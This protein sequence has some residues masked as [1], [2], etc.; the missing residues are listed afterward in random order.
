VVTAAGI[1]LV[2]GD[3]DRMA[4]HALARRAGRDLAGERVHVVAM[5]GVTN[6]RAVRVRRLHRWSR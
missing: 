6:T 1:V 2:E 3:S 5:G 4:L